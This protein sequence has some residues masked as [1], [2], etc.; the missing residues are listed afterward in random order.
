MAFY[1][2]LDIIS[3]VITLRLLCLTKN[4]YKF[5]IYIYIFTAGKHKH[6]RKRRVMNLKCLAQSERVGIGKTEITGLTD[7]F[8]GCLTRE[9]VLA[10]AHL[11]GPFHSLSASQKSL[12]C[13]CAP[14]GLLPQTE[15]T[16]ASKHPAML[17]SLLQVF[18]GCISRWELLGVNVE[19]YWN[20]GI[21]FSLFCHTSIFG[22]IWGT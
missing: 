5:Y 19:S 14:F 11:M 17:T 8:P 20:N 1:I 3:M 9:A 16:A 18:C 6:G 15:N 12:L 21:I 4:I 2:V 13:F 10:P 7:F 22:S